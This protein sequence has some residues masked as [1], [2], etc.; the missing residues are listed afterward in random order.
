M[1]NLLIKSIIY[2]W[3]KFNLYPEEIPCKNYTGNVE[4]EIISL[5]WKNIFQTNE[6]EICNK[7]LVWIKGKTKLLGIHYFTLR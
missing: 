1:F 4:K 3:P 7:K 6:N 5:C 2:K